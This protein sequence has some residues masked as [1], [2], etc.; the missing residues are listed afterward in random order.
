MIPLPS[1][2]DSTNFYSSHILPAVVFYSS[3]I[4]PNLIGLKDLIIQVVARNIIQ[5]LIAAPL[6][7]LHHNIFAL[8]FV[9]G[10][11]FDQQVQKV[12]EKV[13]VVYDA[14]FRK[15]L[16]PRAVFFG[17]GIFFTLLMMPT[18][19]I[20]ATLYHGAQWGANL[21]LSSLPNSPQQPQ[22]PLPQ[23][24]TQTTV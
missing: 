2:F 24:T 14:Q 19:I 23:Q 21:Y 11:I 13:N 22:N 4:V 1:R 16:L 3:H 20:T 5:I 12:V 8:G 6:F 10:F 15:P 17:A 18:S 7:Y 9:I